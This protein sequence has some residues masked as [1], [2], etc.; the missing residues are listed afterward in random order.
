MIADRRHATQEQLSQPRQL[1]VK[2]KADG[3]P[4]QADEVGSL[5]EAS[6]VYQRFICAQGLGAREI[7]E[8][9]VFSADPHMTGVLV[10]E[11]EV[12]YNGRVWVR[13]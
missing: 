12:S 3:L 2:F 9:K 6:Q 10:L 5:Q 13:P 11:A 4:R 7:G 8:A 1:L